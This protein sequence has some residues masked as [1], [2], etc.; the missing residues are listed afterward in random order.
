MAKSNYRVIIQPDAEQDLDEA[1]EY[2]EKQKAGLGFELLE[3]VTSVVE[4]LEGTHSFFKKYMVKNAGL[5]QSV[6]DS[7]LSMSLLL[8]LYI[9][10]PL[11]TAKGILR[12][13][14]MG[15]RNA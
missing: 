8:L 1:Y 12:D 15:N 6:L 7:I 3:E 14:M 13:G 11:Y 4:V 2:M 9:F 10:W 5:L